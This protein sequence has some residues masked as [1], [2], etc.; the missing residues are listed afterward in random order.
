MVIMCE[1]LV[2]HQ[3]LRLSISFIIVEAT[4]H[5]KKNETSVQKIVRYVSNCIHMRVLS[6]LKNQ[7]KVKSKGKIWMMRSKNVK[8]CA[9]DPVMYLVLVGAILSRCQSQNYLC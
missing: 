9:G 5:I 2:V 1:S 8:H 7:E 3:C 4:L 6:Q